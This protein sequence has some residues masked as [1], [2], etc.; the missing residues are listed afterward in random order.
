MSVF[1]LVSPSAFPVVMGDAGEEG[2]PLPVVAA[3][4]L[5]SGGRVVAWGHEFALYDCCLAED[6]TDLLLLNSFRWLAA[7]AAAMRGTE[8]PVRIAAYEGLGGARTALTK[9]VPQLLGSGFGGS[10]ALSAVGSVVPLDN[11]TAAAADVD[12][13]VIDAYGSYSGA[14]VAALTAFASRPG[15][16]LMVMGHAWY[17]GYSN[18]P[19]AV[20]TDRPVNRVLWPLGLGLSS[21]ALWGFVPAPSQLPPSNWTYYNVNITLGRLLEAA[22]P[23]GRAFASTRMYGTANGGLTALLPIL[24]PRT[25]AA[26]AL[27]AFRPLLD[28]LQR[29]RSAPA[30]ASSAPAPAP[31]VGPQSPL[32]LRTSYPA[33]VLDVSMEAAAIRASDISSLAPSSSAAAFPGLPSPP[34][35]A[36]TTLTLTVN[37]TY[38]GLREGWPNSGEGDVAWRSTGAYAPPGGRVTV[39]LLTPAAVGKGLRVQVG[40]HTDELGFKRTWLRVPSAVSS[41]NLNASSVA[42]GNPL[43][44]LVFI[45]VPRRSRLGSVRVRLSGV[46]QSPYYRLGVTKKSEWTN[47]V[48]KHPGPWAELDSGKLVLMFPSRAIRSMADPAPLLTFWNRVMDGMAYLANIPTDWPR[49][50]RFL[51]DADISAGWMHAGYPVMAYDSPADTWPYLLN[52]STIQAE[53]SWGPF[54]ELGHNLQY[55]PMEIPGCEEASNNIFSVY[56]SLTVAG[57]KPSQLGDATPERRA[58]LRRKYFASGARWRRDWNVWVALDTYL[59]LQEGFGWGFYRNVYGE[60]QR[61]PLLGQGEDARVQRWINVTSVVAGRNLVPFYET[62]GFPVDPATRAALARLPEWREDPVRSVRTAAR[63]LARRSRLQEQQQRQQEGERE[64]GEQWQ[65]APTL[66][67]RRLVGRGAAGPIRSSSWQQQRQI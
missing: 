5:A 46:V 54:H 50:E 18:P 64:A 16:G 4:A 61:N 66:S 2:V 51:V 14:Q 48:R 53:G 47:T 38:P 25:S 12:V 60:Y 22:T 31:S 1:S 15:K 7:P 55:G 41:F 65:P 13:Y 28:A 35:A 45:L 42:A 43:G 23:G 59:M 24:P 10:P 67:R 52:V 37:G 20:L 27:P 32:D 29:A 26:A 33:H 36:P 62:W 56:I 9:G 17:W 19:S 57:L 6:D 39:T 8:Q 58:E 44:G 34:G 21:H 40:A 11:L 63:R 30:S 49:Q 3:S